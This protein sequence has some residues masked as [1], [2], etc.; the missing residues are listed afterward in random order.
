MGI[1]YVDIEFNIQPS[2]PQLSL[3]YICVNRSP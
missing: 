1:V 3:T 2:S